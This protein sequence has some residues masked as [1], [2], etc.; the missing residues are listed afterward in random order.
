MLYI[1]FPFTFSF[2]FL[3]HDFYFLFFLF[4]IDCGF[5]RST[6]V[7]T[8]LFSCFLE[9]IFIFYFT[10]INDLFF[11]REVI[12]EL[13]YESVLFVFEYHYSVKATKIETIICLRFSDEIPTFHLICGG[14]IK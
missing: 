2:F 11:F 7:S 6:S 12:F 4:A 8:I 10:S 5:S 9:Y 1:F 3:F 14:F 13:C